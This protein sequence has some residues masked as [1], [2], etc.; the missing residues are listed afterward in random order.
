MRRNN[1]L[2]VLTGDLHQAFTIMARS[3]LLPCALPVCVCGCVCERVNVYTLT[4]IVYIS[5][6]KA[7]RCEQ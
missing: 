4:Y 2:P 6:V 7:L 1:Y 5:S 3:I